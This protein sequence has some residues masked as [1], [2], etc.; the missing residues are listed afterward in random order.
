MASVRPVKNTSGAGFAFEDCVGAFLAAALLAGHAPLESDLGPPTRV[1][2]QVATD[3]WQLD[4]VLVRFSTRTGRVRW[5]VSVK[6]GQYINATA[7]ADFVRRA[8]AEVRGLSTS[9][10][11]G[12]RDLLGLLTA[13]LHSGVFA[14]LQE[15]IRLSRE[16]SASDLAR[17]MTTNG[18]ASAARVSLWTSF[19]APAEFGLDPATSGSPGEVLSRLRCLEADFEFSPSRSE[20][21]AIRMCSE[22]LVDPMR[23]KALWESLLVE[24]S[25]IRTAGGFFDEANLLARLADR[26]ALRQSVSAHGTA[27]ALLFDR[28]NARLVERWRAAGVPEEIAVALAA[29][30]KIGQLPSSL[31]ES[32]PVV[33]CGDFGSGKSVS[34]ERL[35]QADIAA[36][37]RDPDEPV[38]VFLRARDVVGG[39]EAAVAPAATE[40]GNIYR[41]GVRLTLDGLD[42]VGLA[43][44]S[45]L[46]AEARELARL[47]PRSRL[48]ITA[49]PGFDLR[50]GERLDVPSLGDEELADLSERLTGRRFSLFNVPP[51][52]VD[53]VRRPLFAIIALTRQARA[54]E[55]PSSRALMLESLVQDALGGDRNRAMAAAA[56]LARAAAI[57]I[58]GGG[59]FAVAEVGGPDVAAG[60]LDSR[61]VVQADRELRFALPVIEQFFGAHALLRGDIELHAVTEGLERFEPWRYAFVIAIGIGS[62]ARVDELLQ[63]LGD[64]WPGAACW[65][66]KQAVSDHSPGGQSNSTPLPDSLECARRLRQSLKSLLTWLNE[67][68]PKTA[69]ARDDGSPVTVGAFRNGDSLVAGLI[70]NTD[71]EVVEFGPDVHPLSPSLAPSAGPLRAGRPPVE[72]PAWPWRWTMEW[73]GSSVEALLARRAL[74]VPGDDA[75]DAERN[76]SLARR[77]VG[78]RS[79]FH[80]PIEAA[81]VLG[82][83]EALLSRLTDDPR[84]VV[85]FQG[86][87]TRFAYDEIAR[88]VEEARARSEPFVRPWPVPDQDHGGGWISGLYSAER[89]LRL[90]EQVYSA[91]LAAYQN[92]IDTWFPRLA[93]TLGWGSVLPVRL[94]L[95]LKPRRGDRF[96]DEPLLAVIEAAAESWDESGVSARIAADDDVAFG[97]RSGVFQ[98]EY[99]R[100]VAL[101]PTTAAWAH[102]ARHQGIISV[103]DDTPATDLAYHWVWRDLHQIGLL[104][105]NPP[106]I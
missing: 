32:G 66:I 42:E 86:L 9:G 73:V 89:T 90:V 75:L 19:A 91:A 33:L 16:Q 60:L 11:V 39:L 36:F 56:I 8:W 98:A 50:E 88:F 6:S 40:V 62:S 106:H 96:E 81:K 18:Y 27:A 17:R 46:L 52:M 99:E 30:A 69:L 28:C 59:R 57:S 3:G 84:T 70:R 77:L 13:P 29:D 71:D 34:S 67:L 5:C 101:H 104:G 25:K 49:R 76:W 72:E 22:A 51:P 15:L 64:A 31:P 45:Q 35:H 14:D 83:G 54:A 79:V 38:P 78:S 92:L 85:T 105:K 82:A 4:D 80:P 12:A 41:T 100:L 20:A 87:A 23:A 55:L 74:D 95:V 48:L 61:L 21:H 58:P 10:F 94:E 37:M 2:F 1:D 63:A 102:L 103:Y 44:G 7:P 53:A 43:R 26:Y 24:V 47:L 65:A 97:L 93:P 68:T